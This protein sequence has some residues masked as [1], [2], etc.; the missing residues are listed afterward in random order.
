MLAR[1]LCSGGGRPG[2]GELWER[3]VGFRECGELAPAVRS[4]E[5]R[6]PSLRL[7]C[8][9]FAK[10]FSSLRCGACSGSSAAPAPCRP[11]GA[12]V[13]APRAAATPVRCTGLRHTS[14]CPAFRC[15]SLRLHVR[16]CPPGSRSL[17][18]RPESHVPDQSV[19]APSGTPSLGFQS[20]LKARGR[21]HSAGVCPA[22]VAKV[23]SSSQPRRPL[24]ASRPWWPCYRVPGASLL[25]SAACSPRREEKRNWRFVMHLNL[26]ILER[27]AALPGLW[28]SCSSFS[29]EVPFMKLQICTHSEPLF[30][31]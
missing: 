6:S 7:P 16:S 9:G 26:F 31:Q 28:Y 24:S 27:D 10:S 2:P 19:H 21:S 15:P 11:A 23:Q 25:P 14:R 13:S 29:R 20:V 1:L 3:A 22:L 18:P 17:N 30:I 5:P 4:A 8:R 12:I